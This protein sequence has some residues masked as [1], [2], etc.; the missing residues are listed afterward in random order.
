LDKNR[1]KSPENE[2]A[3][4][5]G[6]LSDIQKRIVEKIQKIDEIKS[7]LNTEYR[8]RDR[9]KY[10]AERMEITKDLLQYEIDMKTIKDKIREME[11]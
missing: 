10:E 6:K 7:K 11:S 8:H 9:A 1:D 3:E 4:L 2:I 5:R